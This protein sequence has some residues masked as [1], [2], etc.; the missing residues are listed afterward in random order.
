[1]IKMRCAALVAATSL[2]LSGPAC[3]ALVPYSGEEGLID[4]SGKERYAADTKIMEEPLDILVL[5][6]PQRYQAKPNIYASWWAG[7]LPKD[8]DPTENDRKTAA[9]EREALANLAKAV[10]ERLPRLSSERLH[11][12]WLSLSQL[13]KA[14]AQGP[15]VKYPQERYVYPE[16]KDLAVY[17]QQRLDSLIVQ[18]K[19]RWDQAREQEKNKQLEQ[20]EKKLAPMLSAPKF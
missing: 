3:A 15:A 20:A 9:K 5:E 17:C 11:A 19:E 16:D 14:L 13:K 18:I 2:L 7:S 4:F 10:R 12:L 8:F 1:M 6:G